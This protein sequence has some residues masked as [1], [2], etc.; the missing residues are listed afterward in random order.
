MTSS[1]SLS[2]VDH[3]RETARIWVVANDASL[4]RLGKYVVNDGGFFTRL[5]TQVQGTTTATLEKF[6]AFL[7][8]A[9]NWPEGA[10]PKEAIELAH[11]VGVTITEAQDHVG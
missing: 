5:Q 7:T 2:L 3:L 8:D 9:G 4:T 10:V 6:A 11:R 1:P